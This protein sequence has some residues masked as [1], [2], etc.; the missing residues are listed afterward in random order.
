[1]FFISKTGQIITGCKNNL[2]NDAFSRRPDISDELKDLITKM[3]DKNPETRI[4]VPEIKHI[5]S[6]ATVVSRTQKCAHLDG[7]WRPLSLPMVL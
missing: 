2:A 5:P 4:T 7:F 6:L 1:M 3:L